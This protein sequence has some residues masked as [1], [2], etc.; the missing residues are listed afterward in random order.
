MVSISEDP[1]NAQSATQHPGD[2]VVRENQPGGSRSTRGLPAPE[3]LGGGWELPGYFT[4]PVAD[5]I[6]D[7]LDGWFGDAGPGG[8]LAEGVAITRRD[9]GSHETLAWTL[10]TRDGTIPLAAAEMWQLTARERAAE[11]GGLL[12]AVVIGVRWLERPLLGEPTRKRGFVLAACAGAT[13]FGDLASCDPSQPWHSIEWQGLGNSARTR[14]GLFVAPTYVRGTRPESAA[15]GCM[16]N[17]ED[18]VE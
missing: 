8:D 5:L 2:P 4:G 13:V 7:E 9:D 17:P 11:I 14:N 6:E 15:R 18:R 1:E 16:G 3:H 12:V 10:S